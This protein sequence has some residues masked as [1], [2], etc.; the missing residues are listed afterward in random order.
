MEKDITNEFGEKITEKEIE[1]ISRII[2]K[3]SLEDIDDFWY[4]CEWIDSE[5][6]NN[7]ALPDWRLKKI[8]EDFEFAKKSV[9]NLFLEAKKE[10]IINL[11]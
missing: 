3:L 9:A 7:K 2:H 4:K 10:T 11:K 5:K 6:E 8:K 1:N